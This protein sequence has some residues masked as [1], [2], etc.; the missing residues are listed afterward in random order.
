LC[1]GLISLYSAHH[2]LAY[3]RNLWVV[4]CP[5]LLSNS[6][7]LET[8]SSFSSSLFIKLGTR[9]RYSMMTP[10][11]PLCVMSTGWISALTSTE[12]LCSK[13]LHSMFLVPITTGFSFFRWRR[14]VKCR[15]W[16]SSS[17]KLGSN[18]EVPYSPSNSK[19]K[20]SSKAISQPARVCLVWNLFFKKLMATDT[21]SSSRGLTKSTKA[22]AFTILHERYLLLGSRDFKPLYDFL[23]AVCTARAPRLSEADSSTELYF[24]VYAFFY[25][26]MVAMISQ[27]IPSL[28]SFSII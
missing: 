27:S 23:P 25:R 18:F 4:S 21:C 26:G 8:A 13:D 14:M 19:I 17:I 3:S 22:R 5:C 28:F 7:Y 15:G 6:T 20:V 10:S 2:A 16:L 1:A 12:L 11:V 9:S 24:T